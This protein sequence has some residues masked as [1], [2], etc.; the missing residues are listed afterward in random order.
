MRLGITD[1]VF[2]R[3][4]A[5]VGMKEFI[6]GIPVIGNL[7]QQIYHAW[8]KRPKP[9]PGSKEY[10]IQ[11]YQSGDDSGAGSYKQLAQFKAE[12]L[13]TFVKENNVNTVIEFGCGDG[14]QLK[15]ADYPSYI[16]FDVSPKAVSICKNK[17]AGY[18][19]KIFRLMDDFRQERAQLA[20]SLDVIYHLTEDDVFDAYMTTLFDSAE[21]FVI[22]YSSDSEYNE[23]KQAAHIK[24]RKFSRWITENRPQFQL[25]RHIPN[26]YPLTADG[27]EGS[28]ADFYV[29]THLD[30]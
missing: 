7:A 13:N 4:R 25:T 12:V 16:G 10:W 26:K 22:V 11:R 3:V 14:N 30:A 29:Y 5:N 23:E 18:P 27:K 21:R 9:F 15:L 28:F 8:F 17:F 6:K 20:L 2:V 19:H 24:H 1:L